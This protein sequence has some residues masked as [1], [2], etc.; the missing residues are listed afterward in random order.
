MPKKKK[1][2]NLLYNVKSFGDCREAWRSAG[3]N[4]N[5]GLGTERVNVYYPFVFDVYTVVNTKALII[6]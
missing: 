2:E 5:I 1:K 3:S 4:D 6:Q